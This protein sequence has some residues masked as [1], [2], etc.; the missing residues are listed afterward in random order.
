MIAKQRRAYLVPFFPALPAGLW[1]IL[2][3]IAFIPIYLMIERVTFIHQLDGLGITLWGPSAGLALLL[4]MR[5][6][7]GHVAT[8]FAAS[9][10]TD[11]SIYTGP[12]GVLAP[13]ATSLALAG[14]LTAIAMTLRLVWSLEPPR[15]RQVVAM[16]LIVPAGTL[17]MA[18]TYCLI[19]FFTEHLTP[20][21][22]AIAVRNFWIGDTLGILTIVPFASAVMAYAGRTPGLAWA[23]AVSF[24]GFLGAVGVA[25]LVI[26]GIEHASEYQFFYL[27]FLPVI[28][29]A[30]RLGFRGV[31]IG[32]LATHL[33]LVSTALAQGYATYDFISFQMLM[34][35]LSA[36]G[37]LLG[38]AISEIRSYDEKTRRQESELARATRQALVGATG[39]ALAHEVSQPLAST[40]NYLHAARKLLPVDSKQPSP[41]SEMLGKAAK[42]AERAR[43]TL[44]RVRDYLAS[45]KVHLEAVDARKVA[46]EIVTAVGRDPRFDKV[47]IRVAGGMSTPRISADII[48]LQQVL[49]NLVT[50]AAEAAAREANE[51]ARVTVWF[52]P[53]AKTVAIHVE[54]SGAGVSAEI[55]GRLFEPFES[56][57][58]R[59]MGLGLTLVKQIVEAHGGEVLWNNLDVGARFTVQFARHE[60]FRHD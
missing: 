15:L 5:L 2:L 48:Q 31:A 32:L 36:T 30:I 6:G 25:L 57:S 44:E 18:L 9:L 26:F 23:E 38:G 4:L 1:H 49:L 56:T 10:I 53:A 54:D 20:G 37:L 33:M 41:L 14:G 22:F 21:R 59:G 3:G 34:L 40:T 46:R 17:G 11:F 8:V 13:V 60:E 58:I 24:L 12:R 55:A 7:P 27:L 28:W 19:L 29:I 39:T 16:L 45:G 42:E 43:T 51:D 35:I 50:N 47:E 52:E